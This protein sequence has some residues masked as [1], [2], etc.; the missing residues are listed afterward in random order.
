MSLE[1]ENLSHR[2]N[3][4]VAE[5]CRRA[6]DFARTR[7]AI[8]LDQWRGKQR[9]DLSGLS[10]LYI[11]EALGIEHK[12]AMEKYVPRPYGGDV[13]LFRASKQLAGLLADESLGW[14]RVLHGNLDVCEVPGHQ[15]NLLLEPHVG[16]LAK[17][18]TI[19]LQAAQRRHGA[20]D[21]I[22][23]PLTTPGPKTGRGI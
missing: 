1:T 9:S 15:Q 10:K 17:E 3:S 18:L 20:K 16:E 14:K 6:W 11:F 12:K 7:T 8:A 13:A 4:Y 5:R 22:A 19:R 21:R 2:G 23:Q